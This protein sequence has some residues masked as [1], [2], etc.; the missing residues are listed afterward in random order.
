[1]E[2]GFRWKA[3]RALL[4]VSTI[5]MLLIT[6]IRIHACWANDAY[7]DQVS[8][9]WI[10]LANDLSHGVF[11]RPLF[12]PLGYGGTRYFPLFF[13]L[14][15]ALMK[16]GGGAILT[17]R[18]LS[19]ASTLALLAGVYALLRRLGVERMLAGCSS[20]FVL[21]SEST[22]LAL[23]AI[24]GDALPAALVVW[25][26]A[27]CCGPAVGL[28]QLAI[29][30]VLFT[31][32]FSAK[33]TAAYAL[34]AASLY[35]LFSGRRRQAWTLAAFG[36]AGCAIVILAMLVLSNG[37]AYEVIKACATGGMG[38]ASILHIP[39]H[40]ALVTD[41]EDLSGFPFLILA[42]AALVAWPG[43]IRSEIAPLFFLAAATMTMLIL[44]TPGT[45][46]NHLIDLHAA[47]IILFTVWVYR[48]G[49]QQAVFGM[50]ALSIAAI[51]AVFPAA[52]KFRHKEDIIPRRQEFQAALRIA[53]HSPQPI[54]ADN[55]L[56]PV[57]AGQAPYVLDPFMFRVL[58]LRDPHFADRLWKR[59]RNKQFSAVVL[60]GDPSTSEGRDFYRQTAFGPAF[61]GK[62]LETY[63]LQVKMKEAYILVPREDPAVA[64]GAQ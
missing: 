39:Q 29:A 4:V 64:P 20:L 34:G 24:R 26:F 59:L 18:L 57:L 15:A 52:R 50:A 9:V 7:L 22:Q 1:M 48:S 37:R 23:L 62:V 56:I 46:Y 33:V 3:V 6:A 44:G 43:R 63:G 60:I 42:A 28:R 45:D 27:A 8:G 13:V 25:G 61:P 17:G 14:H 19:V 38:L 5:P 58:S 40:F 32:A 31:L 10:A 47:A 55:P 30:A 11:Y 16:L 35:F 2:K 36:A 53:G 51:L 21:C 12:G 54:L 49:R 41:G